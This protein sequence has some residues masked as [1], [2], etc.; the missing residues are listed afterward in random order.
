MRIQRLWAKYYILVSYEKKS[1]DFLFLIYLK[2][3]M[4]QTTKKK[5]SDYLI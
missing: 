1:T 2:S 5:N 3:K 4:M